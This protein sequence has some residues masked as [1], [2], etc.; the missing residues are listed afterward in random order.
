MSEPSPMSDAW[1]G[2]LLDRSP[3]VAEPSLKRHWRQLLPWLPTSQRYELAAILLDVEH[4]LPC[5]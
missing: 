1:L 4:L 2:F 5:D 3:L